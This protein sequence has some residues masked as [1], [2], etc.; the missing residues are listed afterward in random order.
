MAKQSGLGMRLWVGGFNLS[1]DINSINRIAGGPAALDLT[2]ITESAYERQ[3]GQRDGGIDFTSYFNPS[4]SRAHP[5]LGAL[6]RIDT[7]VSTATGTLVGSPM[8][9]C[10][11]IQIGYDPQ[12][13][14]DGS[15][16]FGVTT[17]SDQYGLEWGESLTA[18]ERTDSTATAS[19]TGLDGGAA[20]TFGAQ[21]YLHLT[22]FT[23]TS[24]VVKVQDS[25]DNATF[26]DLAGAAFT[27]ATA[28][29]WQRIAISN[30]ATVRRYVRVATTGTFTVATFAVNMVRNSIAGQ[31]F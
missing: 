31:V 13:G 25:A 5:V 12:R 18:G 6:P 16:T 4:S 19:G 10:Q 23:G 22:A 28:V 11:A 3:G 27:S 24:V 21:F 7:L 29:G 2:D 8:A 30:A 20:S 9:S 14:Q 1:G 15:L 26:A 17:N